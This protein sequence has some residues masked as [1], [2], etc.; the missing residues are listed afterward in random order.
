M[1]RNNQGSGNSNR[2]GNNRGGS[3]SDSRGRNNNPEGRN[4][5]SSGV[6]DLARDRP[7]AA[8][9]VAAG[10]AAAGLFL[11]SKRAAITD[12][13]SGLS[14]QIGEWK[15]SMMS[16]DQFDD[17]DDTAGLTTSS[18]S[19]RS[20]SSGVSETGAGN[21]SLGSTTGGSGRASSPS[22]RGRARQAPTVG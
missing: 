12:Q 14:D 16:G 15:Q 13:L 8:V 6:L 3:S 7:V 20:T 4:Q 21:A 5:Y 18:G 22:G 10:A 9:A 2:G 17:F 11:W 1:A 19:N